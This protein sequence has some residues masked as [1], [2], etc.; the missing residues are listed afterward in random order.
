MTERKFL[1]SISE[2]KWLQRKFIQKIFIEQILAK[3]KRYAVH[4]EQPSR[5]PF[6]RLSLQE[7]DLATMK[8][9]FIPGKFFWPGTVT[10]MLSK[11]FSVSGR[12]QDFLLIFLQK[13]LRKYLLTLCYEA[14]K[15]SPAMAG[16]TLLPWGSLGGTDSIKVP[17]PNK[18][19]FLK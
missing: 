1:F 18:F 13:R 3:R 11:L 17:T 10:S 19:T 12:E 15:V 14:E 2:F 6:N 9:Q 16:S 5:S 7:D 4:Q 8:I